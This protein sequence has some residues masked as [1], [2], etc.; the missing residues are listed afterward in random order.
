V[1]T[2][3]HPRGPSL[4]T[5]RLLLV[6]FAVVGI[7]GTFYVWVSSIRGASFVLPLYAREVG[8]T[9]SLRQLLRDSA[10]SPHEL[11]SVGVVLGL[12]LLQIA[13][14]LKNHA[15][16]H[17]WTPVAIDVAI[18]FAL[19]VASPQIALVRVPRWTESDSRIGV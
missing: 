10:S 17:R 5:A 3:R 8:N 16:W 15:S 19:A 9:S 18:G 6:A 14:V 12:L 11:L 2:S 4:T 7:L 1:S 13:L